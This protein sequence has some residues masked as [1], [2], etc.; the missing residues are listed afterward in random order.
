MGTGGWAVKGDLS[1]EMSPETLRMSQKWPGNHGEWGRGKS[2]DE[3]SRLIKS[4]VYSWNHTPGSLGQRRDDQGHLGSSGHTSHFHWF[5][6]SGK[7][8]GI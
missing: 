8:W 3:G 7:H 6:S 5:K 4:L 1:G 2:L